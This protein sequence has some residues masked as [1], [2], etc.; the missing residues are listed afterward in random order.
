MEK[1]ILI[2][3]RAIVIIGLI[4][5]I[6]A[7]MN[8]NNRMADLTRLRSQKEREGLQLTS[9]SA[10]EVSLDTQITYAT[11]EPA[12][13]AF[14]RENKWVRNGEHAIILLPQEGYTPEADISP[15]PTPPVMTNWEAWTEWFFYSAP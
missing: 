9:L 10:T 3:K 12:V 4:V 13:E 5:M 1:L 15:T 8:F 14:I 11:S 7:V 2:A 6:L